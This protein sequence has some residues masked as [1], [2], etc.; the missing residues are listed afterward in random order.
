MKNNKSKFKKGA[1][2]YCFLFIIFTLIFAGCDNPII[3]PTSEPNGSTTYDIT[4]ISGNVTVFG[5]VYVNGIATGKNLQG[6]D[7][8]QIQNVPDGAAITL[9]DELE[10]TSHTEFFHYPETAVTFNWF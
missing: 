3:P 2:K 7:S 1:I 6:N 5:E 8:V 9:V 10:Y 4:V